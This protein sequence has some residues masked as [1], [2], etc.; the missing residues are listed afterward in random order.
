MTK[1]FQTI[2]V[3]ALLISCCA[4]SGPASAQTIN[5]KTIVSINGAPVVL[6]QNSTFN[7]A[8]V[9][10]IGST[11]SATVT[12]TGTGNAVGVL[13]FSTNAASATIN[14][15]GLSNFSFVGQGKP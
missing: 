15:T 3:A 7:L 8:G 5:S 14:Q 11:T 13:Q 4:S 2:A 9:F 6:Q 10:Q 12:Q 1:N